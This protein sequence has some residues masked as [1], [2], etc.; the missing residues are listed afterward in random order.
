MIEAQAAQEILDFWFGTP[1]DA[2]HGRSRAVWFRKDDGFDASIRT[3]FS[4]LHERAGRGALDAWR[5]TPATL[6]ALIVLLDQFSRNMHRGQAQAFASDVRALDA[7]RHML[8]RGWDASLPAVQRWFA[9]MPFEHSEVLADQDRCVELMQ[10]LD[11]D[12]A[13]AGVVEW[14]R[15]HRDV[16]ARFGRFPH[17]NA[18]LGRPSSAA[19][20]EFLD[21]PGS[22]F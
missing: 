1:A 5:D 12:P 18:I 15:R 4:V 13:T 16:I 19:E 10:P 22:S 21:Q 6:L 17:R 3:R 11:G 8:A 14:A 7:A 20:I 2:E 9:Y